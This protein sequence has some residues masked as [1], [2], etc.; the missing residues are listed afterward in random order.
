MSKKIKFSVVMPI[1]N[2]GHFLD[3][4]ISSVI[5][6]TIGFKEN[7][8]LILINDGSTDNSDEIC[9]KYVSK[10]PNNIIY[11]KQKNSGVSKARNEGLKLATGEYI[12]FFDADDIWNNDVFQKINHF[13]D[14][15]KNIDL[16]SCRQKYFE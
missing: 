10:Y 11:K 4:S 2:V 6:Q 14:T 7:I 5:N 1:Y 8:E 15:N 3:E 9:K 16:I 13:F 12:N